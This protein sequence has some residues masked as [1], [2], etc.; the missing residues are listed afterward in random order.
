MR[1]DGVLPR[2]PG[3]GLMDRQGQSGINKVFSFNQS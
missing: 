1:A 3:M 2:L